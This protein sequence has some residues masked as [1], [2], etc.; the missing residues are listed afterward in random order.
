MKDRPGGD[1]SEDSEPQHLAFR[2]IDVC[3]VGFVS[4]GIRSGGF[5]G[6]DLFFGEGEV[7]EPVGE[8]DRGAAGGEGSGAGGFVDV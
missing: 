5:L 1:S 4:W 7:G 6:L 2:G 3:G 8:I